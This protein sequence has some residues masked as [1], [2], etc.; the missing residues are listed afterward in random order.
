M[1]GSDT[2]R[3]VILSDLEHEVHKIAEALTRPKFW[4]DGENKYLNVDQITDIYYDA[5]EDEWAVSLV[6]ETDNYHVF[7]EKQKESL[8]K[9][10]RETGRM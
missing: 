7:T 6:G 5:T 2:D 8:V 10:L 9:F 4:W 3:N 1:A